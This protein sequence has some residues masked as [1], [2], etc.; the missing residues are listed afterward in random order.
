MAACMRCVH[1][2]KLCIRSEIAKLFFVVSVILG[3]VE[4]MMGVIGYKRIWN[5]C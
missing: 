4:C 5:L 1:D 2:A 3:V